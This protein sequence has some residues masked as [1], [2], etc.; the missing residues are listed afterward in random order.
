MGRDRVGCSG[1]RVLDPPTHTHT[2]AQRG[3]QAW[4]RPWHLS[5]ASVCPSPPSQR[6]QRLPASVHPS[7]PLRVLGDLLMPSPGSLHP[8]CPEPWLV[9]G[10]GFPHPALPRALLCSALLSGAGSR[11]A[12][13]HRDGT[14][15]CAHAADQRWQPVSQDSSGPVSHGSFACWGHACAVRV[16]P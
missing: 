4:S 13:L 16:G 2:H 1:Q 11:S 15:G 6:L 12:P 7:P 8:G 3:A 14:L 9:Q 5:R 10:E